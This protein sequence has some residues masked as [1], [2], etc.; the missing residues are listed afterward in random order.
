M[1]EQAGWIPI[2]GSRS[3]PMGSKVTPELPAPAAPRRFR[4]GQAM[5]RVLSNHWGKMLV[6][7]A[8]L[9]AVLVSVINERVKPMYESASLLRVEPATTHLFGVNDEPEAF[10]HFLQTQVEL[11]RSPSVI[12]SALAGGSKVINTALVRAA[13]DPEAELRRRLQVRV[14]PGTYLIRVAL[15]TP[16]PA[17]GPVLVS[18]VV[19]AYLALASAWSSE[20]NA[21]R[22]RTLEK[23]S[24][25]LS[26]K[27]GE[28]QNELIQLAKKGT[29]DL[30]STASG[31]ESGMTLLESTGVSIDD[32][33]QI[34][35]RL[36]ETSLKV[37]ETEA[38]LKKRKDDLGQR[39]AED[40]SLRELNEQI[41]SLKFL[42]SVYEKLLPQL[43]LLNEQERADRVKQALVREDLASFREMRS[44]VDKRIEQLKFDSRSQARIN[45]IDPARENR[46]P[47]KD[48]RRKLFVLAP[49][50][51][52]A[53]VLALFLGL[54]LLPGRG[55][56]RDEEKVETTS[57]D[58]G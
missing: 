8:V 43:K 22:I 10:D 23:Y 33:R 27:I 4:I 48:A 44:S 41:D 47:I 1:R 35:K 29:G 56:D 25:E 7:W 46:I 58:L 36:F 54:E 40:L 50:V 51:V 34:R 53:L 24:L 42:K 20:R 2:L 15:T 19:K 14:L 18:E 3:S 45:E 55:T 16:E 32:Y 13:T 17:D 6:T 26:A 52:F 11:I 5:R 49:V 30:Q 31:K 28:K 37:I 57:L 39:E 21:S 12:S 38:L 9:T